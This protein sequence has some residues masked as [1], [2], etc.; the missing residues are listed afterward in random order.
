MPY[1]NRLKQL[2]SAI[3]G[4]IGA[5]MVD[6][7]GEAVQEFCHCDPYEIR[8]LAAHQ[9]ILLGRISEMQS[10]RGDGDVIEDFV[11]TTTGAH[12]IIGGIERGYSLML[13]VE[14]GCPVRLARHHFHAALVELRKEI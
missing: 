14:R 3:P 11:V 7:E 13:I 8:F 2:V 1:Q 5:I 10:S 6:W 4:A 12:L 9:S